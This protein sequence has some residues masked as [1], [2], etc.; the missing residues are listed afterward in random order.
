MEFIIFCLILSF[1]PLSR[2]RSTD[3]IS[4]YAVRRWISRARLSFCNF[5]QILPSRC[6]D[7]ASPFCNDA[8]WRYGEISRLNNIL[9]YFL[10]KFQIKCN[11]NIIYILPY[12]YRAKKIRIEGLRGLQMKS[13]LT[14]TILE[15]KE[16]HLYEPGTDR[17]YFYRF[18]RVI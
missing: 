14:I 8:L 4:C 11:W 3:S 6:L 16:R 15:I 7:D 17:I 12:S 2:L 5:P 18:Y 1:T 13:L 10:T 9:Y